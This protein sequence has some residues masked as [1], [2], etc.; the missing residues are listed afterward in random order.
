[1]HGSKNLECWL[2]ATQQAVQ[3]ELPQTLT[4]LLKKKNIWIASTIAF[5]DFFEYISKAG[6][7]DLM[8]VNATIRVFVLEGFY[9]SN[10]SL[11]LAAELQ[12]MA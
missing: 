10:F 8:S 6:H 12:P 11:S 7:H 5:A 2:R 4:S 9:Y 1:M 3:P